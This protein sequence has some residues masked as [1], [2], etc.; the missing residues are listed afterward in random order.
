MAPVTVPLVTTV[1]VTLLLAFPA[2]VTMTGPVLAPGGTG[3]LILEALHTEGVATVALKVT[4]LFWPEPKPLPM[5][6]TIS[7]LNA[8]GGLTDVMCG[9]TVNVTPLLWLLLAVTTTGPVDAPAGIVV[10]M[11]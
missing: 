9:S 7:P 6:V 3:S 1:K 5:I 8:E 4:V 10:P 2:T 11:L